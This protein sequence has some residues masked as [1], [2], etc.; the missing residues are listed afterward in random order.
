MDRR[1]DRRTDRQTDG[2]TD[3]P[4]WAGVTG[5]YLPVIIIIIIILF[6]TIVLYLISQ[7]ASQSFS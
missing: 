7:R 1:T 3:N 4:C 5:G 2:Q 6:S